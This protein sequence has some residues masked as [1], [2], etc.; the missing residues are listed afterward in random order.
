MVNFIFAPV[1][2]VRRCWKK[3]IRVQGFRICVG[4]TSK[5]GF[6]GKSQIG[7]GF[8]KFGQF[9]V[10]NFWV[11][12]NYW[13][14]WVPENRNPRRRGKTRLCDTR[15]PTRPEF[16]LL[17]YRKLGGKTWLFWYLNPTRTWDTVPEPDIYYPTTSLDPTL[18]LVLIQIRV[19]WRRRRRGRR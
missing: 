17:L 9:K 6:G 12:P 10:Q 7:F 11:R 2:S 5:F 14:S 19:N 18:V 15:T 4:S 3:C 13:C 16:W 8:A 1:I